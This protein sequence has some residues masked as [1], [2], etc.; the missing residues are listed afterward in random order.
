MSNNGSKLSHKAIHRLSSDGI[1]IFPV[2]KNALRRT[3]RA[4]N[5]PVS[6]K[7]K[8]VGLCAFQDC[9]RFLYQS[10]GVISL[11]EVSVS[12][13]LRHKLLFRQE[14]NSLIGRLASSKVAGPIT[15]A[16]EDKVVLIALQNGEIYYGNVKPALNSLQKLDFG[17]NT[18]QRIPECLS[19]DACRTRPMVLAAL[20]S[21]VLLNIHFTTQEPLSL[22]F[23]ERIRVS[24]K[25][26]CSVTVV[27][28]GSF[29]AICSDWKHTLL[30]KLAHHPAEMSLAI[31]EFKV[32]S[33]VW[34][35]LL[36]QSGST[37]LWG[38]NEHGGRLQ[39]WD[40]SSFT[41]DIGQ[42]PLPVRNDYNLLLISDE[43]SSRMCLLQTDL[44]SPDL[45]LPCCYYVFTNTH[46][47]RLIKEIQEDSLVMIATSLNLEYTVIACEG[48]AIQIWQ[49]VANKFNNQNV[50]DPV[51]F[52]FDQEMEIANLS[53]ANNGICMVAFTNGNTAIVDVLY[54][55]RSKLLAFIAGKI[56]PMDLVK[57]IRSMLYP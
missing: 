11:Y 13:Y 49:N 4:R 22:K 53:I 28:D 27:G 51:Y 36:D 47:E 55:F 39:V 37:M 21:G 52:R 3:K 41:N 16:C 35:S 57:V 44:S 5:V 6:R 24:R 56:L 54:P 26:L 18:S 50:F 10:N 38:L 17:E 34:T 33:W 42:I 32:D 19:M 15:L 12:P 46:D 2:E 29:A 30:V 48:S 8:S 1:E 23:V 7:N 45:I 43:T 40:V 9:R 25:G 31:K 14:I 20:Y